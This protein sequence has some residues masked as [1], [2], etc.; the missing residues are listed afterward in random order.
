M[1]KLLLLILLTALLSTCCGCQ[2]TAAAPRSVGVPFIEPMTLT[3]SERSLAKLL[4]NNLYALADFTVNTPIK[5]VTLALDIY[6]N[7][8]LLRT[9]T[10]G[11]NVLTELTGQIAVEDDHDGTS[12]SVRLSN[13]GALIA[14]SW[15]QDQE[16]TGL[17]PVSM[18]GAFEKT[19]IRSGEKYPLFAKLY[20]KGN[21][22][23][24][25]ADDLNHPER[26]KAYDV[27]Y[28]VNCTFG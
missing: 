11:T 8:V 23:E 10:N 6:Q 9:V 22:A 12:F 20:Y 24:F 18:T 13:A 16:V 5:S 14:Y 2:D 19:A 28:I 17:N 1:K 3:D 4:G 21:T 25:S 27:A 26:L 7:G 15:P